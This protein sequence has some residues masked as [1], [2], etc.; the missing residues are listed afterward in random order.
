MPMQARLG[1]A[2]TDEPLTSDVG[3]G[4]LGCVGWGQEPE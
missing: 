1:T 2:L 4:C 3:L